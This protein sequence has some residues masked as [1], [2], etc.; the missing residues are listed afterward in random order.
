MNYISFLYTIKYFK[1]YKYFTPINIS[2]ILDCRHLLTDCNIS[3]EWML[4]DMQRSAMYQAVA[5]Y[6]TEF[7]IYV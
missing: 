7:Y 5:L 1:Y 4:T 2:N 6:V 3:N